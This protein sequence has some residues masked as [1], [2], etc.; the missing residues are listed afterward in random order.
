MTHQFKNKKRKKRF[1]LLAANIIPVLIFLCIGE[2]YLRSIGLEPYQRT[3][4]NQYQNEPGVIW[5][6]TDPALGWTVDPAFLPAEI[7]P[8]GF[9]AAED[10]TKLPP[11]SAKTRVM[12]VGDSFTF[13]THLAFED[14]YASL[15]QAQ[16]VA[17][18]EVYNLGVP[19][20]GVDQ[21]VL[22]YQAYSGL[23]KPDVVILAFIDD[24]IER[25]LEAFRVAEK[26]NKPSFTVQDGELVTRPAASA[27]EISLSKLI[28]K[29]VLFSYLL[30]ESY[31]VFEAKPIV[32]KML[33]DMEQEVRGNGGQLIVLRIPTQ[34]QFGRLQ[35]QR[36]SWIGVESMLADTEAIYLSP[37]AEITQSPDWSSRLYFT[38]G[39]LNEDG[40]R[41]LADFI[42][43]EALQLFSTP[44]D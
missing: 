27:P 31:F 34:D 13:G 36:R 22:A 25:V 33:H 19:G 17:T 9:R 40:N 26:L 21:M 44:R 3:Y 23:I 2:Y 15:V 5:V 38:D 6:Q 37:V 18:H 12:I 43:D 39:H 42:V 10:F 1:V 4:P 7:N 8:Q 30:R 24:D 32:G 35:T 14:S 16:L 11:T 20:Y 28:G 41:L 29:S